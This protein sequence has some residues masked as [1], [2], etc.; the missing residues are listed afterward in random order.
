V[1]GSV[2]VCAVTVTASSSLLHH[3][4]KLAIQGAKLWIRDTIALHAL[5]VAS[6][7]SRITW[8]VNKPTPVMCGREPLASALDLEG[9]EGAVS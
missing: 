2:L 9:G 7:S 4:M 3:L 1:T 5:E 8:I 6:P